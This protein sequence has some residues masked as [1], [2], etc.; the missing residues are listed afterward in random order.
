VTRL[1]T[2]SSALCAAM[3]WTGALKEVDNYLYRCVTRHEVSSE[4]SSDLGLR[5]PL[6][7]F[8]NVLERGLD[9]SIEREARAGQATRPHHVWLP[10]QYSLKI[11]PIADR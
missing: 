11:V 1:S 10:Q 4:S 9:I 7:G 2:L 3:N 5:R 6:S 8:P